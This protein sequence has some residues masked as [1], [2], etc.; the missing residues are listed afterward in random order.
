MEFSSFNHLFEQQN[1]F[2]IDSIKLILADFGIRNSKFWDS[3]SPSES[4]SI[5]ISC[6]LNVSLKSIFLLFLFLVGK[7]VTLSSSSSSS[8]SSLM[9]FPSLLKESLMILQSTQNQK[10]SHLIFGVLHQRLNFRATR[11]LQTTDWYQTGRL[12]FHLLFGGRTSQS[13]F[14]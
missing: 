3:L 14:V 1:I 7:K 5:V 8:S 10:Y 13:W 4:D 11:N 9:S 2:W 12:G 6:M